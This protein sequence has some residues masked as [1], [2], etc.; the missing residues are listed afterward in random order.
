[1]LLYTGQLIT[2]YS[3]KSPYFDV[4]YRQYW[5]DYIPGV[6]AIKVKYTHF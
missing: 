1:M 3:S 6:W 2:M 4:K 5:S